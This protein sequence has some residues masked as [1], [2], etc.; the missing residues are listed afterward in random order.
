MS[1]KLMELTRRG[2]L[3]IDGAAEILGVTP[4]TLYDWRAKGYGPKSVKYAG[5]LW[6][7]A[8]DCYRFIA[9]IE[10]ATAKGSGL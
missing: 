5:K 3:E 9:D 10:A 2:R 7:T 1:A 6:Y 8:E 4:R